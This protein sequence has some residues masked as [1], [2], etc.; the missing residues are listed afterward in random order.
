[1]NKFSGYCYLSVPSNLLNTM[2]PDITTIPCAILTPLLIEITSDRKSLL[3][4][5]IDDLHLW[6]KHL[7]IFLL[8]D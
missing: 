8:E 1:M 4:Q 5:F 2:V 3:D 6:S 7:F